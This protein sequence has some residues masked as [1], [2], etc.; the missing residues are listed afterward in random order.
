MFGSFSIFGP[1]HLAVLGFL[2]IGILL[3]WFFLPKLGSPTQN[4]VRKT[5]LGGLIVQFIVFHSWHLYLQDYDITRF[6]PFHLCT[7][8]VALLIYTL[9]FNNKF[10]NKLVLFWSP[11]SAFL[12]IVLPDMN[13]SENF[14]SFRFL[15]FFVSH[16]LIIWAVIYIFRIQKLVVSFKDFVISCLTLIAILPFI[17]LLNLTIDSNYMYLM[18]KPSG[19]QMDFLPNEPWYIPA[20]LGIVFGVFFLEYLVYRFSSKASNDDQL[21]RGRGE[22]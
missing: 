8:S 13:A 14:P 5:I 22:F 1:T 19:G 16:V 18:N 12:A 9:V 4:L 11:V 20:T 7:I 2:L 21:Y 3:I 15:E 17:Y 10:I 6:L